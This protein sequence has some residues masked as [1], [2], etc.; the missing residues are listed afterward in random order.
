MSRSS[1][2]VAGLLPALAS[3]IHCTASLYVQRWL[4]RLGIR[5]CFTRKGGSV[6]DDGAFGA[7]N[8]A[9]LNGLDS[10]L[11][12]AWSDNQSRMSLKHTHTELPEPA[13]FDR[14]GLASL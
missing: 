10:L 9:G 2:S 13:Y 7:Q 11:L 8:P 12:L 4:S 1:L 5:C 3:R 6:A 14:I